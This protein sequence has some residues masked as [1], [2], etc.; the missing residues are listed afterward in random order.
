MTTDLAEVARSTTSTAE[1]SRNVATAVS[2]VTQTIAES[3][4]VATRPFEDLQAVIRQTSQNWGDGIQN[5]MAAVS[6]HSTER[7]QTLLMERNAAVEKAWKN[8]ESAARELNSLTLEFTL[9]LKE[10]QWP[11]PTGDF[12]LADMRSIVQMRDCLPH[13]EAREQIDTFMLQRHGPAF[14][15]ERLHDWSH[16]KWIKKRMAILEA[17]MNAHIRGEYELSIPSLLP[18]IEGIIWEGYHQDK[19]IT[20]KAETKLASLLCSEGLDFL[21]QLASEFFLR[22]LMEDF[23]LDQPQPELSRHAILHGADTAYGTAVNSLK[24]ILLFDYFLNAFGVVC[25][26]NSTTYHKLG[27][28]RIGNNFQ[29]RTVYGSH[30][31]AEQAGKKPCRTCH[32]EHM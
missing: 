11:P 15:Q 28:P 8:I 19:H 16:H 10:F 31:S 13:E 12:D 6:A 1:P 29:L 25:L 3:I 20:Q 26:K 5:A 23:Q 24:L 32:P 18:Q 30:Q 7:L 21:D 4:A 14:I 27:C 9:T 2:K 17:V 22:T